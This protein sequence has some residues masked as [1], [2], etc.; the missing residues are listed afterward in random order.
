[1]NSYTYSKNGKDLGSKPHTTVNDFD[2]A[3]DELAQFINS[4]SE[5]GEFCIYRHIIFDD[6][7]DE[8]RKTDIIITKQ[9]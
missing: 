2:S 1:M 8:Y 9:Q 4:E 7:T 5:S 3:I 6:G